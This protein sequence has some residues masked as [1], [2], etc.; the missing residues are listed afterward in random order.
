MS[1]TYGGLLGHLTE[2]C[3]IIRETGCS[4]AE[5]EQIRQARAKER[6]YEAEIPAAKDNVIVLADRR[7]RDVLH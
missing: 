5:A 1:S 4:P 6:Q 7:K 2:Q 3:D